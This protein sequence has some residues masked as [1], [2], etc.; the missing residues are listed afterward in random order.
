MMGKKLFIREPVHNLLLR[1]SIGD[2]LCYS[3]HVSLYS[4]IKSKHVQC[5][6]SSVQNRELLSKKKYREVKFVKP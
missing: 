6:N 4:A 3:T 2:F 5:H 1:D